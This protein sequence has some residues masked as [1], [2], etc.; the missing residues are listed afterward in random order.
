MMNIFLLISLQSVGKFRDF[1]WFGDF[2][3][4]ER[5]FVTVWGERNTTNMYT[6]WWNY[7]MRTNATILSLIRPFMRYHTFYFYV[8]GST[9]MCKTNAYH[10]T[11][12]RLSVHKYVA[13]RQRS[14]NIYIY[15]FLRFL[16]IW[17]ALTYLHKLIPKN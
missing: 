1:S 10:R 2:P 6:N 3:W 13:T 8:R 12:M 9:I 11:E 4:F 5:F 7:K 14:A 15:A 16:T 17:N